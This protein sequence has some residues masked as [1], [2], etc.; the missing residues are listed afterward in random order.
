MGDLVKALNSTQ[1]TVSKHLKI[2]REAGFVTFR[3]DAQRRIYQL[4][5]AP[6]K[7]LEAWLE[8]YRQLWSKNLDALEDFLDQQEKNNEA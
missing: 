5:A 2:L 6:F 4:D 1:P 8:P 3:I 7:N